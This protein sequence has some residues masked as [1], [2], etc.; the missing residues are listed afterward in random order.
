MVDDV[1]LHAWQMRWNIPQQAM[2]ELGFILYTPAPPASLNCD[3]YSEDFVASNLLLEASR[4]GAR[5]WRNN[6]GALLDDRGIPVRYGLCNESKKINKEIKSSDYVGITPILVQPWHVGVTLG[7]FTA[8]ET[9]KVGWSYSKNDDREKAQNKYLNLVCSLG[10]IASFINGTGQFEK[11][12]EK[13]QL[14]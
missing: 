11:V 7:V 5:L 2:V 1:S 14:I 9:K 10:G 6:V 4:T 3:G 8:M 13:C 12:V